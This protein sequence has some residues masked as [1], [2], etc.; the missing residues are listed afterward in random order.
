MILSDLKNILSI[1]IDYNKIKNSAEI[2]L[3]ENTN[4]NLIE[5][6]SNFENNVY[7]IDF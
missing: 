3:D 4:H 2:K 6:N 1:K 7:V 5:K